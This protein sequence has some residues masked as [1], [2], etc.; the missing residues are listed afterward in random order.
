MHMQTIYEKSGTDRLED[1]IL[2]A[3][4]CYSLTR[5]LSHVQGDMALIK[6]TTNIVHQYLFFSVSFY[7]RN[8]IGLELLKTNIF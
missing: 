1:V 5:E 3:V 8:F 7:D 6:S 4:K 2:L